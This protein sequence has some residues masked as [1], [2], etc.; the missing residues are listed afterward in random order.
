M[1]CNIAVAPYID[2]TTF[3][4]G[5]FIVVGMAFGTHQ[6]LAVNFFREGDILDYGNSHGGSF[7][8]IIDGYLFLDS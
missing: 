5:L 1:G 8:V 3:L 7:L 2:F 4:F 6:F